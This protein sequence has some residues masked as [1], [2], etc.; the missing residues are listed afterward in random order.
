MEQ[1]EEEPG[2]AEEHV[3]GHGALRLEGIGGGEGVDGH[4]TEA[5]CAGHGTG[6]SREQMAEG[7]PAQAASLSAVRE[8]AGDGVGQGVRHS[9]SEVER[10]QDYDFVTAS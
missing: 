9:R 2:R 4:E 7:T 5:E 3:G 6:P 1:P 8:G 10:A